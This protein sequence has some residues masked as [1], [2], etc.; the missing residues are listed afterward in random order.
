MKKNKRKSIPMF[1]GLNSME[2]LTEWVSRFN[3]SEG[4]VAMS[5]MLQTLAT[6]NN[7]E[8]WDTDKEGE[9]PNE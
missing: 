9:I 6:I 2:A 5:V 3:G 4:V 1:A 8:K 7:I